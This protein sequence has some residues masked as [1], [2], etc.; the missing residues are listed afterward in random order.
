MAFYTLA[1]ILSYSLK[2][3]DH[4]NIIYAIEVIS[5]R[6]ALNERKASYKKRCAII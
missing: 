2:K 6:F 1:K 5:I 3:G 4:F